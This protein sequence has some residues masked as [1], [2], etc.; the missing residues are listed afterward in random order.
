MKARIQSIDQLKKIATKQLKNEF[1]QQ[2]SD[3]LLDGAA[4]GMAFTM[5]MLETCFGWKKQRQQ[6]LFHEMAGMINL[7]ENWITSF[8]GESM[9]EHI[10]NEF[11][12][13]LIT[14]LREH[15]STSVAQSNPE[16]K[17]SE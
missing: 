11:D 5:W 10:K 14:L 6:K 15:C 2:L 1:D 4:Q 7:G 12:V 9:V 3:A 8:N 16:V 13:D 17:V